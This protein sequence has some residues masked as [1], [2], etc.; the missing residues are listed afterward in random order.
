MKILTCCPAVPPFEGSPNSVRNSATRDA[1]SPLAVTTAVVLVGIIIS[2]KTAIIYGIA[3]LLAIACVNVAGMLT[4][5]GAARR[6]INNFPDS[7]C[8][9][10]ENV[11]GRENAG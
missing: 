7:L 3:I 8:Q 10:E 1:T 4:A 2:L 9:P 6:V 11:D 5:R